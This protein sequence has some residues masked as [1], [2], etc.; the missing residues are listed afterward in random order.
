MLAK[1]FDTLAEMGVWIRFHDKRTEP[2]S[3]EG[4]TWGE[5]VDGFAISIAPVHDESVSVLIKNMSPEEK[6]VSIPTW[7]HYLEINIT[8]V[9]GAPV[10]LKPYGKQFLEKPKTEKL[11]DRDFLPGKYM[12][13]EIPIGALYDLKRPGAYSL[14][15]SCPVPGQVA[16]TAVSRVV[17]NLVTLNLAGS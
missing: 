8:T 13:I 9:D 4:R 3:E 1:L 11:L 17:S 10:A 12:S 15:L 2:P 6:R 16:G 5:V 14:S 7:L